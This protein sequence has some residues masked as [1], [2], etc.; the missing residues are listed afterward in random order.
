MTVDIYIHPDYENVVSK[1]EYP[2]R[3]FELIEFYKIIKNRE[4]IMAVY[5]D[6]EKHIVSFIVKEKVKN[7]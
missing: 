4:E 1:L 2:I 5:F 3:S 6:I 7:G